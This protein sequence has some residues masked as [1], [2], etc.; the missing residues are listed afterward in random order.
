[1]QKREQRILIDATQR[2]LRRGATANIQKI[3]AKTH[4][5]DVAS[6]F[7][8]LVSR[9]QRVLFDLLPDDAARGEVLGEL[10]P[11]LFTPLLE[12]LGVERSVRVL[13][14]M[15]ADDVADVLGDLPEELAN[16]L[17]EAMAEEDSEEV[18]DLM[19]WGEDTAGGIMVPDFFALP[20]ETTAE[21]AIQALREARDVEMAFYVY[22][23]NDPGQLVG[24]VSLRQ[25]V[26]VPPSTRLTNIMQDTVVSVRPEMDQEEVAR[27]VAR[28]N[29]LAVPVV[30]EANRLLGIVTVDDIIDVLREE[31]TEDILKMAGAGQELVE[32]RSVLGSVRVRMPW[33]IASCIGGLAA[34]LVM[35]P[36]LHHLQEFSLLALFIP[37][38]LGMG[39][40]IGTQSATIIVRGLATGVVELRQFREVVGREVLGGLIMG[41]GYG[42]VVGGAASL[43]GLGDNGGVVAAS[44]GLVVGLA[45]AASMTV[46]A[47]IGSALPLVF[48]RLHIDPAVATGPFVTTSVDILGTLTYFVLA[49]LILTRVAGAG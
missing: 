35:R 38:V 47:A 31:A 30:D 3:L 42:L 23:L 20:E 25:L 43:F 17:L 16:E 11:D 44:Y 4:P 13:K 10:Q 41:A 28:Y 27:F 39:G 24:V 8:A 22:V 1:M 5:V 14:E 26:T 36:F 48:E 49:I 18:E 7:P 34:A 40:N 29:F 9:D 45:L 46:A 15:S 32:S 12:S 37:V 21:E 33:L 19:R 2:L 6:I